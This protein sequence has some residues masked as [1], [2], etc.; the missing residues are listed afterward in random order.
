M[1]KCNY[2]NDHLVCPYFNN[3][4]TASFS[5]HHAEKGSRH[6]NVLI[7]V[8]TI[9]FM[10][11][12]ELEYSYESHFRK[13]LSAGQFLLLPSGATV[14]VDVLEASRSIRCRFDVQMQMCEYFRLDQLEQTAKGMDAGPHPLRMNDTVRL[15]LST[16]ESY[17]SGGFMC[18]C[19]GKHKHQELMYLLRALYTRDELG[20]FFAPVINKDVHFID[21]VRRHARGCNTVSELASKLNYSVSGF[22]KRFERCFDQSAHSWMQRQRSEYILRDLCENIMTNKEIV[23]AYNFSSEARFYEFCKSKWGKTP[24]E[25]RK[26]ALNA[27]DN[28]M[29]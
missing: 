14:N 18:A 28:P 15:Y 23:Y 19:L 29:A 26:G 3:P 27:D 16:V 20:G 9:V 1:Q 13:K 7:T 11:E 8:S 21:A 10:L 6:D 22:N 4:S 25:I 2:L 5:I 24:K 17:L 12:G